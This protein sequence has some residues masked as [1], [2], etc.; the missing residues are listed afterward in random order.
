M[1]VALRG[2]LANYLLQGEYEKTLCNIFQQLDADKNG[3]LTKEEFRVAH[4]FFGEKT[5]M[6]DEE[7]D[8]IFMMVDTNNNG[9]IDY[10][11]FIASAANLNHLMSE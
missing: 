10:S 7:I 3:V 2:Y 1:K 8:K 4:K 11:E 9:A 6:L 5:Y